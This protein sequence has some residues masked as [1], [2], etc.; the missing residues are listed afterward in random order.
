MRLVG[1]SAPVIVDRN[2]VV[3][4]ERIMA[5]LALVRPAGDCWLFEGYRP[6]GLHGRIEYKEQQ[7][8]VHRLAYACAN[9]PIPDGI[10]VLHECD[11]PNCVRPR[12][13]FEGTQAENVEDMEAKGR[14]RKVGPRGENNWNADLTDDQVAALRR[15]ANTP[16][17]SQRAVAAEFGV[18]QSTVWRLKHGAV[19]AEAL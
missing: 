3:S 9:G 15:R 5:T 19:R 18:S 1:R 10:H 2:A 13:L 17:I 4:I 8:Y 7:V 14:A 12:H 11:V 16:G 6:S